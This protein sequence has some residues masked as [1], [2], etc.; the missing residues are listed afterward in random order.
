MSLLGQWGCTG[1]YSRHLHTVWEQNKV[2][3]H[4]LLSTY[5][6][7]L[8]L[9]VPSWSM[10][11]YRYVLTSPTHSLGAE[12]AFTTLSIVNILRYPIALCP[13][14][15]NG[16]VQVCSHV[17]YT[18]SGSRTSFHNTLYCQHTQISNRF[19]SLLGQWGCTGM[20]SRHLHTVW[21]QNKVSQHSLLSTYSDILSLYV[22][23]WSMGLY[24]YVL[25]SPTHSLGAE[26]AF[27]TLSI[28]NI[29]RNPIALCP[30]LVIG[31][32]QVCCHLTYTQSGSRTG[33]HN[34]LYCQHTQISY[35][36]MSPLG[37]WGRTSM[38]SRHLH[39]V[40]EQN[41]VSQHSL[42]STYSDIL[43]LYVPSW[44]MGLCR[45][46]LT[47]P[48][49][50]LG[51][52]Q[53]FTTLSIVNILRYSIAL[54]P[55]L[56]NGAV[57]VC[58]HVTYTQ[59]RS[60]TS[61]HNPLYCQHTQ[62]SYCFM[63]LLGQ[64]GC[65]GLSSPHLHTVSEQNKLSQP[66]LLSTYSDILSLYVP[67]WSMGLYR[68]V[69]TSPTHSLGAEQGFT[70]LSIVNILRYPIALCPFLVNG[71]V[72]VCSHV[73][74]T[75]SGSRT[76]FHNTLYCQHTQISYRFMS[77]LGQWNCTGMFSRHLHTVWEQNKVSQPSLLSTYSDI[78]SLYVP[79]WSMGLYRYVL[80]SP[81]HSLGAEQGF[82]TLSIVNILRYPIDLCP[83]LVNGTVQVCSHVTYTQSGSRTRFHNPLYC[84][85]TQISYRFMSLLG[86]WGCTGM[87][88]RH[89]HTVWEQNKVSQHS[90]LSTY[91]DILSLY[92]PSWSMGLYRYVLTSP[93]HSLG[94]EQG[95]T[96]L[97]I[98][99]ILRYPIALCP[100]LVNG[101]VQ[102]CSHLTYTQSRSRTRFHNT[103]YCQHTQISYRFM[104]LLGQWG[105][106][107]MFSRHLHTVWEQNKLSQHSLLSTYSDILSLYV[108][109]W[110]MGLYR[111]VLTS[112]TH[113]LGAKQAFTTLSIV[114]ILRYPIALCHF[115]VNG[116]VQVWSQ[117][118]YTQSG[119][120][121]SFHNTPY[122]Q[123]TQISYCFM[124][125][126][127]QWGCTGMLSPHLHTVLEQNKLSQ[128]SLLSTYSDILLLYVPSWSMG[129]YRYV[130]TS[131]T[132]S[133][134]AEQAFKTLSIV[135]ILIYPIALCPFLVNGAVQLCSHVT[136]TQSGS[137]TS[138][139]NTLYCQH[140]HISYRFMSLL[141]QWGR[142]VMFSRHL[143]T[144]WEQNKLS[145]HSLLSTY[146][147]I[148][149]LYVPSWSM[150]LYRYVLTS[151][152]HSLGA[153]QAFTT[154]SIVNILRYPIALCPFLVNEAVQ[155]CS[156]LTYTQS[157]TRT[158]FHNTLYCQHTQI[159][160]CFMS[161]LGQ[162]GCT[163]IFSRHLH[164]VWD[165][166][167]LSQ[168]SLLS[169]YSDILLLYVPSWSM[170]LYR[171]I[172]TSPT[173]SLG[174]EQAFTTLSIVNILRYPIAFCPFLVNEAVQVCPHLT[175]TQSR[176][177]TSF[178]TTLYCQHTHISYRFMSLL[179]QCSC[180]GILSRH[181]HTV[182]GQSKLSQNSFYCQHTQISYRFMSLLG[183]CSCTGI[184][185]RHLHTVWGQSKLSQ[186]S[187]YCQH[188]QIS[189][190]FM[191]LLGQ[192]S[193][194]G[195]FSPHLHTVWGQSKLS[196]NSFYCQH[197][198]I[199]YRFISLLGQWGCTGMYA[200][201]YF[202]MFHNEYSLLNFS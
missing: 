165:Q 38:L 19:M 161:L 94:A 8:S 104:S 55:F 14:L 169:A 111:Y 171:Y 83:F 85:H 77:L 130:L 164:T 142:T 98:V 45:Y 153:K 82:T 106:T 4:S 194:T 100:F 118:T 154:L 58:S 39:T 140:T 139:H 73:T 56:V 190:R 158:S 170:G 7:I 202:Q 76:R 188:T 78:L 185:S 54:S 109:S 160:Y 167:K 186:N 112:P 173:H 34:T 189:Y 201:I 176:S 147:D 13:F 63:S 96:T 6:D 114:N 12:Q 71:A 29:L 15:V 1:M 65:T 145:Q 133:L 144:V 121:I 11:L 27:T 174:A 163:G 40:W 89:L 9:Y 102:V 192:W 91:S 18:Q 22:P 93:T 191:S 5:S 117:L 95:F 197:T 81:T 48:T 51:A 59:S 84:Q 90:L 193:C 92:V 17:T 36:F 166:N 101:A 37:H 68:F 44:S 57:Q 143:H 155:V 119:R 43:S 182:W 183:Q 21:E 187:F 105:C 31:A 138:F 148:L 23:S 62:I 131:P 168:H 32:V 46:V 67:S 2:S 132:H 126:L 122:C 20:F 49:H 175:Y 177:R 128:H 99:N 64:W 80:T 200:A 149:L 135:N 123:H 60:R 108:P 159:S 50:S 134:G 33:N 97:S 28:V 16:A 79:S 179:G 199:S 41:K 113:S 124:S 129:L 3:Q 24:R 172:L 196:Q 75:Q 115:L 195:I 72:Q 107:G 116:T 184:L 137:R 127:G 52:E 120:R 136:Y 180:T 125:L 70:T 198:Q 26:Q 61:F 157:G 35:R 151:P 141:G 181:L 178:L 103:L 30:L 146:S 74:Y 47:S 110:S 69:L 86:Q 88:S 66:S 10:G 152:T 25:T 156:H 87:F 53:G 162:W 150:G 42:L